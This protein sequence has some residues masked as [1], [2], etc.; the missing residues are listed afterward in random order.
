MLAGLSL[1]AARCD[2]LAVPAE[3]KDRVS[4]EEMARMV[5]A[6]MRALDDHGLAAGQARFERLHR[7]TIAREGANSVEAADQLMAFGLGLHDRWSTTGDERLLA[8]ARDHVAQSIPH[9]RSAFG[10]AHPEV[11]LA[12]H[13]FAT[14]DLLLNDGQ[15]SREALA[16]LREA[17]EIRRR[18]LGPE[19]PET[20]AAQAELRSLLAARRSIRE[21]RRPAAA[22]EDGGAYEA[23]CTMA[24]GRG[25]AADETAA[26][27]APGCGGATETGR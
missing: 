2:S 1:S 22:A 16:A 23:G 19:H 10:P 24:A 5:E 26:L 21:R 25:V 6:P 20:L 8:A 17:R 15:P 14:V 3:T 13:S 12:L 4:A 7:S 18:A 9:Y 27:K 11:A